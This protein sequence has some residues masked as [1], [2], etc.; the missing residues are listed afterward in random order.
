M[1]QYLKASFF[2]AVGLASAS[3]ATDE[4]ASIVD[5]PHTIIAMDNETSPSLNNDSEISTSSTLY[6][7]LN[8]L[9]QSAKHLYN[10]AE[11][12]D[13]SIQQSIEQF[14]EPYVGK[15][16]PVPDSPQYMTPL[17]YTNPQWNDDENQI[18]YL[19]K[20]ITDNQFV[21]TAVAL[22]LMESPAAPNHNLIHRV[23]PH[24]NCT[25]G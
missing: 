5:T 16:L 8:Y 3:L 4:P 25:H 12:I 14:L 9:F 17:L 6:N 20:L 23:I 7:S 10:K 22:S 15:Y 19:C 1:R 11:E 13:Q 24:G 18:S 21:I 2:L